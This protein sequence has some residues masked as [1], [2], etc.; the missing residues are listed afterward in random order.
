ML[1]FC[2]FGLY[3]MDSASDSLENKGFSVL[4]SHSVSDNGVPRRIA[5]VRE[6]DSDLDDTDRPSAVVTRV[7]PCH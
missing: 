5:R 3:E 6:T 4:A 2:S 1:F 7:R